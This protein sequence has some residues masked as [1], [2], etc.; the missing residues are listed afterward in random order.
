MTFRLTLKFGLHRVLRTDQ[1]RKSRTPCTRFSCY[2]PMTLA[3]LT[4][5]LLSRVHSFFAPKALLQKA[6]Y[7]KNSQLLSFYH[8]KNAIVHL[9]QSV[10]FQFYLNKIE[11]RFSIT[12]KCLSVRDGLNENIW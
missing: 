10:Q 9:M 12:S 11:N 4:D 3:S 8:Q 7:S 1:R 5:I 2:M 6:S